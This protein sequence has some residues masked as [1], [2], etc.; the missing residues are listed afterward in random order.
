MANSC[1]ITDP[2]KCGNV[3]YKGEWDYC[4]EYNVGDL[5]MSNSLLY[6]CLEH[7][8]GKEPKDNKN[9]W[10]CISG[11]ITP[12]P[13]PTGRIILDGGYS[14]TPESDYIDIS[15]INGGS[16]SGRVYKPLI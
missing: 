14:S 12:T 15:D 7:N 10:Y 13:E 11:G 16:S 8:A 4:P 5:V 1:R 3:Y 2:N 9:Y 6:L